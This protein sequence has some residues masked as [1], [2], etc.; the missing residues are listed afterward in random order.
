LQDKQWTRQEVHR[1]LE[2]RSK[3]LSSGTYTMQDLL[4]Q[5]INHRL[6]RLTTS[7]AS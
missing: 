1:L 5:Q 2:E 3:L 7:E 6:E 4:I